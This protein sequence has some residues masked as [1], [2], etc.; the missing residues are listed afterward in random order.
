MSEYKPEEWTSIALKK[1]IVEKLD[2]LKIHPKQ[3]YNE[4]VEKLLIERG[5]IGEENGD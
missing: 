5:V 2:Q 1:K 3:N 4:I